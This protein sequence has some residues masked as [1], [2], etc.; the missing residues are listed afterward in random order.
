MATTPHRP[1]HQQNSAGGYYRRGGRAPHHLLEL[2]QCLL[3]F[4]VQLLPSKD[5]VSVKEDV[6]LVWLLE[7][8]AYAC[9]HLGV[10]STVNSS[11]D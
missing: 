5:E 10:R 2:S 4:V 1:N 7:M 6:R 11:N 9:S 3:D 8:T